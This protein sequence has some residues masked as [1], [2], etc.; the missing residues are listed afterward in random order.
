LL[1]FGACGSTHAARQW[2]VLIGVQHH[3]DSRLDLNF[4]ANDVRCLRE[5]L[6]DRAEAMEKGQVLVLADTPNGISP[7]LA[8]VRRELSEFLAKVGP[9]DSVLLFFSGHGFL[10]GNHTYLVPRDVDRGDPTTTALPASELRSGLS[11]C[12]AKVK[13]LILDCC[14]AG[15]AKDVG[16][17][18]L[19]AE[20]VA[21]S[22]SVEQVSGCVILASCSS[23]EKSY[24]W[25]A[26]KQ[27]V[28]SYW[29]CR[30]LEGGADKDGNG[31]VT[32]DEIY[33]YVEERV[34]DSVE[35]T[36]HRSQSP[37]RLIGPNVDGVWTVL[38]LRPEPPESLCCRLAA[39][40]DEEVRRRDLKR[41]GILE[42]VKPF[43]LS[44]GLAPANLPAYLAEQIRAEI[45]K[46]AQTGL[47]D[48]RYTVIQPDVM[49]NAAKGM[50]VEAV[51]D[52]VEMQRLG[53]R[54]GG[55]DGLV[56]GTLRRRGTRLTV[57]CE[58]VAA[59]DGRTLANPS[60]VV[61]F[62]LDLVADNGASFDSRQRP[63]GNS[64]DRNVVRFVQA[65]RDHPLLKEDFPFRVEVWSIHARPGEEIGPD[66]PRKR[67]EFYQLP[68]QEDKRGRDKT[69]LY[70]T[71]KEGEIFEI[72]VWNKT[73][74]PVL[75]ALLVDGL[76]TLA[77]RRERLEQAWT[78]FIKPTKTD[79]ASAVVAG[80]YLPESH[81]EKSRPGETRGFELRR[82]KFVDV[83]ESVAGRQSF[84]ESIGL[85][86]AAFRVRGRG[87]AVG[88]GP[89]EQQ[90]LKTESGLPGSFLGVVQI[91]YV[92]E[93]DV[94]RVWDGG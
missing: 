54:T 41:I 89:V 40:L 73:R 30:G 56:W 80:W 64:Y 31:Q 48:E 22:F 51:G 32:I 37:R 26:K 36:F 4:T 90:K 34:E 28:F 24:E 65:S 55:L 66:T 7:T 76:N 10:H 1:V 85:I 83:A 8:N 50:R 58:L 62:S 29:L 93:R 59:S 35:N 38:S 74:Q 63:S 18:T 12:R 11:G 42:F 71:A 92:D 86:T 94:E 87:L 78:W 25:Q 20:E 43:G 15:G 45:A 79:E 3:E 9:D 49:H 77:Q 68:A 17:I 39:H 46:L 60:G 52:P 33:E 2:A 13:L 47:A 57:E 5:T 23:S 88:E 70:V 91:R 16:E 75:M 21:K 19:T 81:G 82:F 84:G 67:K 69:Q 61:P 72:R 27:S 53:Q 6:L 14:H 44:E